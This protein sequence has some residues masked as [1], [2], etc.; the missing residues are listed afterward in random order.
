M[1]GEVL[2]QIHLLFF[3]KK[4]K[5]IVRDFGSKN[6]MYFFDSFLLEKYTLHDNI[7]YSKNLNKL[8]DKNSLSPKVPFKFCIFA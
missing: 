4:L 2:V 7:L 8:N 5:A 3:F 6:Y 1:T